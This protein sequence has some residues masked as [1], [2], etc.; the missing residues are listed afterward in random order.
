M[1]STEGWSR[2]NSIEHI[3]VLARVVLLT[4]EQTMPFTGLALR[5]SKVHTGLG[6]RM[7]AVNTTTG[8]TN[9]KIG[10]GLKTFTELG[11]A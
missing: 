1:L 7:D 4:R 10:H 11:T 2:T 6:G 3:E 5:A 9:E 8:L